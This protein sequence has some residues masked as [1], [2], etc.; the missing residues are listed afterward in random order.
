MLYAPDFRSY[1]QLT[2]ASFRVSP[3]SAAK[4]LDIL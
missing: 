3:T 1:S 4:R 2:R